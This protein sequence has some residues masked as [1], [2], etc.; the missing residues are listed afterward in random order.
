M[1]F[2]FPPTPAPSV[3]NIRVDA[4]W[5]R[6]TMTERADLLIASVIDPAATQATK[7]AAARL[8][9][10]V[11][12]INNDVCVRLKGQKIDAFVRGLE[13]AGIL[14]VGRADII[15]NTPGTPEEMP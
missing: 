9:L 6:F 8:A 3:W 11:T 13:T 1:S 7:R 12:D 10:R 15:L 2:V 5:D 4:F 14:A